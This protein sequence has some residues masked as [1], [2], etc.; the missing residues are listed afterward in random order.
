MSQALIAPAFPPA[1][2]L[3]TRLTEV[4]A[5]R[6]RQQAEVSESCMAE[7]AKGLPAPCAQVLNI[8]LFFDGTNNHEP[9]DKLANPVSTSNVARLFHA[10]VQD[11]AR[12]S[13]YYTYYIQGVGTVFKEI[14]ETEPSDNGLRFATGGE[15]R[16]LW[17][18]T[19]L[20]DALRR[21]VSAQGDF[22]G[23]ADAL[24][25]IKKMEYVRYKDD[26]NIEK[27]APALKADRKAAMD[28]AMK[29]VA[30]KLLSYEPKV[31]RMKLF[32]YGFSRGAAEA[33]AFVGRLRELCDEAAGTFYG[34]P[35][36]IEFLGLFDTVASVG[37]TELAP[38]ARGHMGWADNTM[39]LPADTTLLKGCAHLV[40]GHEQ[41]LCFPL[42]SIRLKNG[43]YPGS[44]RGEW[45]YPGMHSDVGGGYPPGDQG[46]A[47][48]GQGMLLSQLPLLHMYRLAF[49]AGAPLQIDPSVFPDSDKER[50]AK[51][52]ADEPWRFMDDKTPKEFEIS[53]E[54]KKRFE[55]WRAKAGSDGPL[56]A[57]MEYQT[58]QITA[59]R[60]ARYAGGIK[61]AGGP[62]QK[63]TDYYKNAKDTPEWRIEQER[64]A[65]DK[66][67][68][69]IANRR[70]PAKLTNPNLPKDQAK[71]EWYTPNVDKSYEPCRDQRQLR[72]GADDFRRAYLGLSSPSGNFT[73]KLVSFF[74]AFSRPFG[75]DCR[76]EREMLIP[77][78]EQLYPT[79][80]G[81][82]DLMAL[83]DEHVHDSRAWFMH[84]ALDELE[85]HGSYLRYRTVFFTD[86]N[87]NKS[88]I[89][90]SPRAKDIEREMRARDE[91]NRQ[92]M[93]GN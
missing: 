45:V 62:G 35:I 37:L 86:G 58:A 1:G 34:V 81:D 16:I 87:N 26:R 20:V 64:A 67:P 44:S 31:L 39:E 92:S 7:R 65:W 80:L 61:G 63:D 84:S 74:T 49:D 4:L 66:Q 36:S 27:V 32:V 40:S 28:E 22:L 30:A 13:G 17:G 33:R 56:E 19:R 52:Q 15:R 8:S 72:V 21:S 75:T 3:P 83:Y 77:D 12:P 29:E 60:I 6:K 71:D 90:S 55:A 5:Q 76:A 11:D 79:V 43:S 88:E 82:A 18:L 10:T 9:S 50:L 46:K 51:L 57:I 85:P 73:G 23:A 69:D 47:S 14:G 38:G 93:G 2:Y 24:A 54:L 25:L 53:V 48:Q 91:E 41:R 59:W 42:D 89:C 70:R 78:G 68:R